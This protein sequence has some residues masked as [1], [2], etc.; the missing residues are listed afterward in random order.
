MAE[1]LIVIFQTLSQENQEKSFL[2][3]K[4]IHVADIRVKG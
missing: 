2:L 3:L 4:T 1:G